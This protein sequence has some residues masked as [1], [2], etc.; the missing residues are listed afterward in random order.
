MTD[1]ELDAARATEALK[2]Y[3]DAP[4]RVQSLVDAMRLSARLGREGWMPPVDPDLIEARSI[5][6]GR[7]DS[8]PAAFAISRG[9]HDTS[10]NVQNVLAGIKRGREL[11]RGAP[12]G[13]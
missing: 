4:L 2:A 9:E 11:E 7:C 13:R 10:I 12:D 1:E 8:Y 5:A 3:P 6:A